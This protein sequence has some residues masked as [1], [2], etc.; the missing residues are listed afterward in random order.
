M[1]VDQVQVI[2]PLIF[3]AIPSQYC[4]FAFHHLSISLNISEG[5]NLRR[6]PYFLWP[7]GDLLKES[8]NLQLLSKRIG[9]DQ[10]SSKQQIKN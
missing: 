1:K 9:K 4:T 3:R 5:M 6:S 8:I 10:I 7:S 2:C